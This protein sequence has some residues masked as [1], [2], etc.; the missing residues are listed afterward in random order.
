MN[1]GSVLL[2]LPTILVKV[3][4][5]QSDKYSCTERKY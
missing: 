1:E 2:W 4:K 3:K 5:E